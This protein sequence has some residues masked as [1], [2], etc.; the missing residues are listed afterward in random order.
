VVKNNI[1]FIL[2]SLIPNMS[3]DFNL[4]KTMQK[5][6]GYLFKIFSYHLQKA[7]LVNNVGWVE[8]RNPTK[9]QRKCWV[10]CLN[11]TYALNY[12]EDTNIP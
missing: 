7:R 9:G 12:V 10:S 2:T 1:L 5:G 11:P 3:E 8:A 6:I 4:A